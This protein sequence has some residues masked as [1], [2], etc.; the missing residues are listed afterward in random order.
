YGL[1]EQPGLTFSIPPDKRAVSVGVNEVIGVA[2]FVKPGDRVD[3]L[4]TFDRNFS[5]QDMTT[6]ILQDVQVLATAQETES[7]PEKAEVTTTVTLAVSLDE[8]ER[9]TLA[10][11]RGTLRLV[12]RP[13]L[14][15]QE[16]ITTAA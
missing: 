3:V 6:T 12:L 10:E 9:L 8:A 13:A 1:A 11:E 7:D 14:Y 5:G 4:A 2:G 15:A 16:Q